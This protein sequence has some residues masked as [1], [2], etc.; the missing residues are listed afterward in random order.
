MSKTLLCLA[1]QKG[2]E[3]LDE[4]LTLQPRPALV[5]STMSEGPVA[6]SF[7]DRIVARAQEA[8]VGLLDVAEFRR[9]PLA[10]LRDHDITAIVCVGWRYLIPPP[11]VEQLR[12]EVIVAHD[13][14]LPKLRGFAP[15]CTALIE[16]HAQ[17]GVTVARVGD[18]VDNGDILWQGAFDIAP[19]DTLATLIDKTTPLYRE[20]IR[21]YIAGE[22][23]DARPQ[24]DRDA[25]YSI[26]R[27]EDD[28]FIDWNDDARRIDRS[29]RALGHPYLG[30]R[31][32]IGD[33]VAILDRVEV[34][35]DLMFAIRQ[36]GKIWSMDAAGRPT[37]VCGE[38]MIRIAA[39]RWADDDTSI[40][41][42]KRLRQRLGGGG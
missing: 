2:L 33:R 12:G 39:A 6:E 30:A 5:V 26:W 3:V 34:V 10:C 1:T 19:D 37:V 32:T 14:L 22:L 35:D 40:F 7:G 36:P 21:R 20:G 27:N 18:G 17:S 31:T 25:T 13:S 42:V 15:L 24:D 23:R 28:L 29:V 38:G 9:D 16:G 11:A 4:C 41:P 8:G